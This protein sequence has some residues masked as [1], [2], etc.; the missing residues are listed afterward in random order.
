MPKL[1]TVIV[2]R[3]ANQNSGYL[4]VLKNGFRSSGSDRA[5]LAIVEFVGNPNDIVYHMAKKQSKKIVEQLKQVEAQKY[6]LKKFV[7]RDPVTGNDVNVVKLKHK[8]T[9]D[10]REKKKLGRVEAALQKK[11][12]KFNKSTIRYPLSRK[13]DTSTVEN[14]EAMRSGD[15]EKTVPNWK[16]PKRSLPASSMLSPLKSIKAVK[17]VG[18][19][20]SS[21]KPSPVSLDENPKE[22]RDQP[23]EAKKPEV[24]KSFFQ[25]FFGRF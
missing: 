14:I 19:S 10:G 25:R 16:L 5:P 2:N 17:V 3:Y 7:L 18:S 12:V 22:I 23:V 8:S 4:R 6:S 20:S 9:L 21:T 11:V 15:I 1:M 13:I 24:P